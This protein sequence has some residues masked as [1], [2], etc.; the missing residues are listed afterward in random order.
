M[1]TLVLSDYLGA[2]DSRVFNLTLGDSKN[3][4]DYKT[5]KVSN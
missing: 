1:F 2:T 4:F 3:K 5:N